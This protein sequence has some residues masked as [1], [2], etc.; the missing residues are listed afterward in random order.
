MEH[1]WNHWKYGLVGRIIHWEVGMPGFRL[2]S[3]SIL[4]YI[5]HVYCFCY[6]LFKVL[7]DF[8]ICASFK[9]LTKS[10][11]DTEVLA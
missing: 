1:I 2:G 6:D 4:F 3:N 7:R 5:N 11:P 10:E 8:M 9:H